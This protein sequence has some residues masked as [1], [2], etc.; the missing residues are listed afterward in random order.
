MKSRMSARARAW[1]ER[2]REECKGEGEEE[3]EKCGR[4]RGG[5]GRRRRRNL[6]INKSGPRR[7]LERLF[8]QVLLNY[9]V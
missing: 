8:P 7:K 3:E 4:R 5:G 1:D 9:T 6:P 2:E